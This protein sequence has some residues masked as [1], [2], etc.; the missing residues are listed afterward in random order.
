MKGQVSERMQDWT[1]ALGIYAL[2]RVVMSLGAILALAVAH[3]PLS[4]GI[5]E[6]VVGSQ[7]HDDST[8][9][10]A[11]AM[12]GYWPQDTAFFPGYPL[13]IRGLMDVTGLS[14]GASGLIVAS[15]FYIADLYLFQRMARSLFGRKPAWGAALVWALCPVAF[16]LSSA[17]TEPEFAFG[18]LLCLYM[19]SR[20]KYGLAAFGAAFAC[21]VRNEGVVLLIPFL[22]ALVQDWRASGRPALRALAWTA[23]PAG[24]LLSYAGFLWVTFG[25]PFLFSKVEALWGRHL[26]WPW[27]TLYHGFMSLPYLFSINGWYGKAYYALEAVSVVFAILALVYGYRRLPKGWWWMSLALIAIPL[28][29]PGHGLESITYHPRPILDY[30]F[31]FDRFTLTMIPLWFVAGAAFD[32]ASRV[33]RMVWLTLSSGLLGTLTLFLALGYF[34]G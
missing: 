23:V 2:S 24:V 20:R 26:A 5:Y 13:L 32:R 27:M 11:I 31:S 30:F 4:G 1:I 6:A 19:I 22:F 25:H 3:V 15:G 14:A 18:I 12:T 10:A 8:W 34:W 16:F 29:D 9:Y 7:I 17:Y 33:L 28:C 21:A